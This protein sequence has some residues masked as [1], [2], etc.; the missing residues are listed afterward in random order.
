MKKPIIR[1]KHFTKAHAKYLLNRVAKS[2]I[3][4]SLTDEAIAKR[5]LERVVKEVL[6]KASGDGPAI[7]ET[8]VA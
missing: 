3:Q 7:K 6:D 5:K 1:T 4:N 2:P 8:A